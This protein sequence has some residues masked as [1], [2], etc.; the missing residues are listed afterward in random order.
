MSIGDAW[1]ARLHR[2]E[3][4]MHAKRG[5]TRSALFCRV[6]RNKRLG[7][8]TQHGS[9]F[10]RAIRDQTS[11]HTNVMPSKDVICECEFQCD[12]IIIHSVIH[13]RCRGR[14]CQSYFSSY[15]DHPTPSLTNL[16]RP[17]IA[18]DVA[19]R[20]STKEPS[21]TRFLIDR[22]NGFVMLSNAE[23]DKPCQVSFKIFEACSER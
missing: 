8:V 23:L 2:R 17:R 5:C 15:T 1:F 11:G 19:L 22:K 18:T 12:I 9:D 16:S 3:A 6:E 21:P 7:G 20:V 14:F 10:S 13:C 4:R